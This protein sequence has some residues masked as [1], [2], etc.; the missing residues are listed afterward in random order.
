MRQ[1]VAT[2]AGR[3]RGRGLSLAGHQGA[4]TAHE[5]ALSA[6]AAPRA[7]LSSRDRNWTHLRA[8]LLAMPG[9]AVTVRNTEQVLL[10]IHIGAPLRVRCRLEGG[11]PE[12]RL[13]I[14]GDIDI[15]PQGASG[16]WHDEAPTTALVLRLKPGLLRDAARDMGLPASRAALAPLVQLRDPR[17]THLAWA[18]RAE[19]AAGRASDRLYADSLAVALAVQLLG[20]RD[21]GIGR[22][23]AADDGRGLSS[24]Q[25]RRVLEH[26]AGH[27]DQD[28]SLESLSAAAG[29]GLSQ[30]KLLFRASFG[31]P[32]HQYVIRR[33][34]EHAKALLLEGRM[35]MAEI[36]LAAGFAH[37]SH[38]A[39]CMRRVLG[40][41]PSAVRRAIH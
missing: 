9:G 6:P 7:L 34:V 35:D 14:D 27:I 20:G 10:S 28:L 19:L 17:L 25:R 13:L 21:D 30:F 29:L 40:V 5:P 33:R 12:Q 4:Q 23:V 36:A 38:M 1:R 22:Q 15:L 8:D 16:E 3:R 18:I 41:S 39:R 32:V 37:Q 26:I 11:R 24:R 31:L 2:R